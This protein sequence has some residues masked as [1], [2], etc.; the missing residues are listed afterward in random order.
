MNN[1]II[2]YVGKVED[3]K[4]NNILPPYQKIKIESITNS[5][6]INQKKAVYGLLH[7]AVKDA[8]N[9]ED[10]F[11]DISL[12]KYGKPISSKYRFSLSLDKFL[13]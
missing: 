13:S 10:D 8:F 11:N 4:N 12:S 2:V 1:R 5:D 7:K 3:Y 9:I 6:T